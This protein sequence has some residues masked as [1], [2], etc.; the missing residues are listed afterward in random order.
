[1]VAEDVT[2]YALVSLLAESLLGII[3]ARRYLLLLVNV[4]VL[5]GLAFFALSIEPVDTDSPFSLRLIDL[6]VL[7]L[8]DGRDLIDT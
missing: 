8:Y 3:L 5:T 4:K 6:L 1:M 7:G 2:V